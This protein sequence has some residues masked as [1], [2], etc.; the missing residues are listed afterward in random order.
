MRVY[1]DNRCIHFLK[2]PP[3]E[4]SGQE[5]LLITSS[6]SDIKTKFEYFQLEYAVEN[7]FIVAPKDLPKV[8]REFMQMFLPVKAS[9]GLVKNESGQFLFI[10]RNDRWDLPKGKLEKG[11][12]LI[13]G[14][15]REVMEETGIQNLTVAHKLPTTYH[16]FYAKGKKYIKT[17]YWFEMQADKSALLKPQKIENITRVKWFNQAELSLPLNSTYRS[18]RELFTSYQ[19]QLIPSHGKAQVQ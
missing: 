7:L 5:W 13:R 19:D 17:T 6:F 18:V 4:I 2:E 11:E 14:A 3:P 15:V 12:S 16:I 8:K 9:G 1:I 10:Y